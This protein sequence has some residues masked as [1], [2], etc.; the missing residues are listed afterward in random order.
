MSTPHELISPDSMVAARG[1]SH[2]VVPA[3]GRTVYVA[4]QIGVDEA[5]TLAG[6][7]LVSQFEAALL[8]VVT[9]LAA[10]GAEPHDVVAMTI[11]TTALDEYRKGLTEIGAAWRRHMGR[12][13][14]A[15]AMIGVAELVDPDAVVEIVT[16]AVAPDR[17]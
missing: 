5:G 9:A 6:T 10:A 4:G 17:Q 1:F 7:D 14:P 8:N 13:Y 16:V 3:A 15:M 2:A 11:Y 12:H